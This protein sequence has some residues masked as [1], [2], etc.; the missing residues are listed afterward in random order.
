VKEDKCMHSCVCS[1]HVL[2]C[3]VDCVRAV[4][5]VPGDARVRCAQLRPVSTPSLSKMYVL[6]H[7]YHACTDSLIDHI[8]RR[9]SSCLTIRTRASVTLKTLL[10]RQYA[11]VLH[12]RTLI[13]QTVNHVYYKYVHYYIELVR[14]ELS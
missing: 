2:L 9:C 4:P 14:P 11:K 12:F 13:R 10:H 1:Y 6:Q 5:Q 3:A 7:V 8:I